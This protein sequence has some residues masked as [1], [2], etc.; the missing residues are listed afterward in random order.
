MEHKSGF[1][2]R[3]LNS[4]CLIRQACE[5]GA[6]FFFALLESFK[7]GAYKHKEKHALQCLYRSGLLSSIITQ[8]DPLYLSDLLQ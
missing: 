6:P 1:S 5:A 3:N 8:N 2:L 4:L 7:I